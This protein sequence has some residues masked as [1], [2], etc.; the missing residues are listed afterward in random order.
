MTGK[1]VRHL[2]T[3]ASAGKD[4]ISRGVETVI[5]TMGSEGALLVTRDSVQKIKGHKVRAVDTTVA[6]DAFTGGL[7]LAL[8]EGEDL[9]EAI[10]FANAMG[11]LSV[12]RMGAQPAL[13]SREEV[14]SFRAERGADPET[15][16]TSPSSL[17]PK[18]KELAESCKRVRADIL[19]MLTKARSG[20]PGG[21]LS[22]VE[23]L[24][25]LYFHTMVYNPKNPTWEDRDR[26]IL[27][28][29]HAAPLLYA[30]LAEA[31][32]FPREEI[33]TLRQLG[34]RLQGHPDMRR[35]PG[36]DMTTGSLGQGLSAANGMAIAAKR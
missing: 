1:V 13:P 32:F 15:P 9:I 10:G 22:G 21:S 36:V 5:I 12:T 34:S 30:V 35:T 26:F 18:V 27:S 4:L 14:E 6:G 33:A 29:G 11:A 2:E 28:K 19:S 24:V 25:T 23:L 7:A 16:Q 17:A 8:A 20:H 3:A 31:G